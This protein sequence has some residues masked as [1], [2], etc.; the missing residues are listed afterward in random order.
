MSQEEKE[1]VLILFL[2]RG[3]QDSK[4][5]KKA[6]KIPYIACFNV[7]HKD[8]KKYLKEGKRKIKVEDY[9]CFVVSTKE[10]NFVYPAKDYK[11][12]MKFV[13]ELT[14]E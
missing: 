4:F 9:P 10:E 7:N 3:E 11:E 8:V 5:L 1:K 13:Q 14:P 2:H 12:V 6:Q